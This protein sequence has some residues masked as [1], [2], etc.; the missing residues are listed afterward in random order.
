MPSPRQARRILEEREISVGKG[1][2]AGGN[3]HRHGEKNRNNKKLFK[4]GKTKTREEKRRLLLVSL[5]VLSGCA[6]NEGARRPGE[7]F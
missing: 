7:Y 2:E 1:D 5:V 6:G 3:F 4:N